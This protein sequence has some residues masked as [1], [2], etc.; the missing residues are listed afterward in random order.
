MQQWSRDGVRQERTGW[1]DQ[2]L[3]QRHR[4][5][6][7]NCPAVDLDFLIVEYNVGK[8]VG[9]IEYKHHHARYPDLRHATYRALTELANVAGLPFL[10]AF[11]WPGIWAFRVT[12]VNSIANNHF[13]NG[14]IVTEREFVRRLYGMRRR[15]LT[16]Y[17]EKTLCDVMPDEVRR[18]TPVDGYD[19]RAG[20]A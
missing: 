3:S 4:V 20:V 15:V 11:Y 8:P 2:E 19:G 10:L 9:L 14:E 17:L 12:P 16:V 7:H 6:G 1:R 5:W 13:K 18:T